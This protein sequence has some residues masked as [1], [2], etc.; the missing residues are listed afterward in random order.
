MLETGGG[1]VDRLRLID[2]AYGASTDSWLRTAGLREGLRVVEIGCGSGNITRRLA[3]AVGPTGE[4]VGIDASASQI[5]QAERLVRA[6]G[7]S[8]VS[9]RVADAASPNLPPGSFDLAYCRLVLMHMVDPAAAIRSMRNLV[10]PGGSVVCE[11][12]DLSR[13]LCDPPSPAMER[14]FALKLA[15]GDLRGV[16][17]RIGPELHRLFREAGFA[18]THVASVF[19]ISLLDPF[20]RSTGLSLQSFGPSLLEHGLVDVEELDQ[21]VSEL[22]RLADDP[23]TLVGLPMM[24]QAWASR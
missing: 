21:L 9:F 1:D 14:C 5:E 13:W 11:E 12:M 19:A 23:N 10:R 2:D 3:R 20:K 6:S 15:L 22:L 24:F 18:E 17:F 4:V 16:H 7:L 8:N